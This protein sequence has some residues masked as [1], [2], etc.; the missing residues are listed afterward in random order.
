MVEVETLC[1]SISIPEGPAFS[2]RN[3]YRILF[4]SAVFGAGTIDI[5]GFF[6][7]KFEAR[8]HAFSTGLYG[9]FIIFLNFI[10][11]FCAPYGSWY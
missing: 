5:L 6:F 11:L 4:F 1:L 7:S 2:T 8:F 10:S 3:K 9:K